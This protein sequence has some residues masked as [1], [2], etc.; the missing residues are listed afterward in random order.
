MRS[1][2]PIYLLTRLNANGSRDTNSIA[3]PGGGAGVVSI[4][5]QPDG[6]ILA[7]GW[8]GSG[9][10]ISR[11]NINGSADNTFNGGSGA[12]DAI[13]SV[14]IQ[15]N[16]KILVAGSFTS[17]N[18]RNCNHI[19]RLNADGTLDTNFNVGAGVNGVVSAAALQPDGNVLVAGNFITADGAVRPCV[20]RF[21]GDSSSAFA[22]WAASYGLTGTSASATADPES[23]GLA[24]GVEFIVG[25][26]PI[27]S[28][29]SASERP[30]AAVS[31]GYL[32][33]TL[34]R[35]D[36]SEVSAVTLSVDSSTNLITWSDTF[37]IGATTATSSPGVTISENGTAPDLITVSIPLGAEQTRFARLKVTIAP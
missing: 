17:F 33:F 4:V 9:G 16:G 26:N 34:L 1:D 32:L 13:N 20:A 24:N 29:A 21:Y 35:N 23:D 11:L 19:A 10:W 5:L 7:G 37:A 22:I 3:A 12:D 36:A 30:T 28:S 8:Y 18:G 27:A 31:S 2:A 15:S 25:G 6:K 14:L